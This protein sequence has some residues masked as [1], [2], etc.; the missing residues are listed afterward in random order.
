MPYGR[1]GEE[2]RI[3][4]SLSNWLELDTPLTSSYDLFEK[5]GKPHFGD[6]SPNIMVG[7]IVRN[8]HPPNENLR[9]DSL[10]PAWT[11]YRGLVKIY[12]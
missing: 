9:T 2:R 6:M 12:R 8:S 11:A 1:V 3:L 4:E 7:K 10:A 5:T